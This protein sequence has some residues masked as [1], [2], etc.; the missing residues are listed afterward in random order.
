VETVASG[1]VVTVRVDEIT[2]AEITPGDVLVVGAPTHGGRP[3]P[4]LDRF[5]ANLPDS[6]LEGMPFAAFDTRLGSRWV[7]VFGYAATRIDRALVMRDAV[8]L[9]APGGFVVQGTRGPLAPGELER[10]AKWAAELGIPV[11][12]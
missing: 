11:A 12:H 5:L 3:T 2:P 10:A 8:P 9:A 4:A 7:A 6:T 1:E